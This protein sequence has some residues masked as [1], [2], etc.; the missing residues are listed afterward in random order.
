MIAENRLKP[1]LYISAVPELWGASAE[2]AGSPRLRA[3]GV[4]RHRVR[5]LISRVGGKAM[6]KWR[7]RIDWLVFG[8]LL[9]TLL[10]VAGCAPRVMVPPRLDLV[11]HN[12]LGLV[13][14]TIENAKGSLHEL[15]TERFAA[16]IF[17]SQRG[18]EVLE[19]G[20]ADRVLAEIGE[21]R[22]NA[23]A[24]RAI[25]EEYGVPAVFV[26]H[27]KVSDVKPRGA[28]L[29]FPRVEATVS[30]EI[31]VRLLSTESGATRWS[32]TARATE[33][34]GE[35]GLTGGDVYFSA[36]D[37]NEAYGRLVDRLIAEVTADLRP[38]WV[39]G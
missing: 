32:T 4:R 26:G 33:L 18:V 23:R 10:L 39:R 31:T 36:E 30:V 11:E 29:R 15:A 35:L 8:A 38:T 12:L 9:M 14:F 20:D 13:T 34:V 17:A 25:G 1:T 6:A 7:T 27:L 3:R 2:G 16:E 37:P 24:A 22:L 28:V 5:V 19:L 21:S